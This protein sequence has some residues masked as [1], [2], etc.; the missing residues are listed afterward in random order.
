MNSSC[1]VAIVRPIAETFKGRQILEL[2][3][4]SIGHGN[5]F[6]AMQSLVTDLHEQR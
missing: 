1:E 5:I 2:S 3:D 6:V 4:A